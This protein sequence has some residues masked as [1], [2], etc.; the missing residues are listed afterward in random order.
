M[1]LEHSFDIA[2]EPDVV[3]G[4]LLDVNR[5]AACVPG[6]TIQ[7]ALGEDTFRG[8]LKVKV[9]PVTVRYGGVGRIVS[10]DAV[11]RVATIEAEGEETGSAGS[12][13]ASATMS[14]TPTAVGSHVTVRTDLAI[15]GRVATMGKGVIE[16]VGNRMVAQTAQRIEQA[17]LESADRAASAADPAPAGHPEPSPAAAGSTSTPSALT[18]GAVVS[19]QDSTVDD[20]S[21]LRL[22]PLLRSVTAAWFRRIARRIFRLRRDPISRTTAGEQR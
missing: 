14:V 4:Y 2:A 19:H 18:G 3:F 12:V 22:L 15:A 8:S 10:T 13:R 21:A 9:G 1:E 11:A 16:Q 20:A 5:V 7:E 17:I 6:V